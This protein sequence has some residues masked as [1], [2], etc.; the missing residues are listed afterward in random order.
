M[1]GKG[2]NIDIT[3]NHLCY[4]CFNIYI[5]NCSVFFLGNFILVSIS[6]KLKVK[7]NIINDV[8]IFYIYLFVQWEF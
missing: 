6:A 5:T 2:K 8:A 3:F 4:I 7:V 1:N